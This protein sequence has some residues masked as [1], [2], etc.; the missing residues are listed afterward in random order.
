MLNK[1]TYSRRAL[2]APLALLVPGISMAQVD[3]SE[4]ACESCP[5]DEGYRA[6][7]E[8]GA[9]NVSDDAARFGNFT[10]YDEEGTYGNL[11][12]QGR[13]NGDGYRLDYFMEDLGLDSRAFGLSVGSEGL[14]EVNFGYREIPF[15]RFDTASTIF[16]QSSSDTLALPPGW[17]RAPTTGGMS[18]LG[19]SLQQQLIGTDRQVIDLGGYWDP[20]NAFRVFADFSRQNRDGI[21]ITS[22]GNYTSASF[23]PRFIDYETDQVDAGVQYI[24]KAFSVTLG[25]YGSF[26]TNK[27]LSLTWETPYLATEN[28]S[29]LRTAQAPDNDFQQVS[30]S[31]KYRMDTWDTV[32]AFLAATGRGEQNAQLLAYSINP[33]FDGLALPRDTLEGKID[34]ANYALTLTTRPINKLRVSAGYRYDERDNKTPVT[35][36]TRVIVDSFPPS[37]SESNVPYSYDRMHT[38]VS[39]EYAF[40]RNLRISAGYDYKETNRDYQE[41]AEQTT[42]M[43]WGQ[44]R[45]QP[46]TWLDIRAKGGSSQRSNDRYND[47]VAVSYGQ[48]PLMRKYYLAYRYREFGEAVVSIM[49]LE[50]PVSF[51]VS[52]LF[53]DDDYRESY[54][55]LN[56]S[57]EFRG[58]AD[59]SWAISESASVYLVYGED[60]IDA[61]QT[62]S[63]QFSIWD[64][65]AFHEDRFSHVGAGFV[66]RPVEGKFSMRLDYNRGDGETRISLD[67]L[68]G[69]YS[70]LPTLESTLDSARVEASYDIS[71]RL[72]A[73]FSLRYEKFEVKDWA[74]ISHT[75]LPTILS[76]GAEPYNYDVYAAGIGIRYRFG[77]DE[78]TLAE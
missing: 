32:I 20:R 8:V 5:F 17:V 9:T 4:W 43:G 38:T 30:L 26:F 53:A 70:E 55:G 54:L 57:E 73:T 66:W 41:V 14:F 2:L 36:W 52:A 46:A 58:T 34:T 69:G 78:I 21:D 45:W 16:S 64:W 60:S 65:S 35:N 77:K 31:G 50:S 37:D 11:D 63:E 56:G 18:Q 10:G 48:N 47:T 28:T 72:A 25:W 7:V 33:T 40:S 75:T 23:L 68:S 62:G 27:N 13:Y 15:R 49:P 6:Q 22:A 12:G 39:A 1:R 42:D 44:L 29:N 3:T 67:S 59:L 71:E 76:M 51:S 24:G 61:H 19:S 74:L